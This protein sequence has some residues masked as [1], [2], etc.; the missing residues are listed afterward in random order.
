MTTALTRVPTARTG[1]SAALA[2]ILLV[3]ILILP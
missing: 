1:L 2:L 3:V